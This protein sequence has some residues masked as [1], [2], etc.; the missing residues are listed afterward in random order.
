MDLSRPLAVLTPTVDADVLAALAR[1]DAAFTPGQLHRLIGR[2]SEAGVRKCLVRLV[3]QGIVRAERGGNAY[4][5]SL[6]RAHLAAAYVEGL[7]HLRDLLLQRVAQRVASWPIPPA[8]AALFGSAARGDMTTRSDIDLFLVR[9]HGVGP[10]DETWR[11]AVEELTRDV[12]AWTGNDAR[13][14]EFGQQEAV[15]AAAAGEPVFEAIRREGLAL[16]GSDRLLRGRRRHP[17]ARRG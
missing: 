14:L 9:P 1:A 12:T 5:Y 8:Y 15:R 6:N 17:E 7:A 11:S 10:D 3:D 16:H 4:L 2:H 13:V